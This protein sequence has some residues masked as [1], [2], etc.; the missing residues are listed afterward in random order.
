MSVVAASSIA[1]VTPIAPAS[2][3]LRVILVALI[4]MIDL[5]TSASISGR[6][7]QFQ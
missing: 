6:V 5:F 4:V 7:F 2:A 3:A 1:A